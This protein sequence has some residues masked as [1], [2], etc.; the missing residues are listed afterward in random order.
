MVKVK[1][2]ARR[3]SVDP[4]KKDSRA[5]YH[6]AMQGLRDAPHPLANFVPQK[7]QVSVAAVAKAATGI[8]PMRAIEN[9]FFGK[10]SKDSRSWTLM[11]I[12][13]AFSLAMVTHDWIRGPVV[14]NGMVMYSV[15]PNAYTFMNFLVGTM[16]ALYFGRRFTETWGAAK[17]QAQYGQAGIGGGMTQQTQVF[18]QTNV[19]M[20]MMSGQITPFGTQSQ[21]GTM[22]APVT[23]PPGT[24]TTT[25]PAPHSH[26]DHKGEDQ[27]PGW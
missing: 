4:R 11:W 19:G 22:V 2:N 3:D 9:F 15:N 26:P 7:R 17:Q 10:A 1:K 25:T 21:N 12:T 24:P 27:P 5:I 8:K 6:D 16:T 13:I 23:S 20:S 14:Q 18:G